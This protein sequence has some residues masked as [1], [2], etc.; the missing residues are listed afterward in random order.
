MGRLH[1]RLGPT[2]QPKRRSTQNYIRPRVLSPRTLSPIS[3][4]RSPLATNVR[5]NPI[6]LTSVTM[7]P[8]NKAFQL[9]LAICI[10]HLGSDT[11]CYGCGPAA[12][13][14]RPTTQPNRRP[15]Q[16]YIRFPGLSSQKTSLLGGTPSAL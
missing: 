11:N 14:S 13:A 4:F 9:K 16:T 12:R 10:W 3:S 7:D 2:I 8:L 15:T 6:N 1:E 5:L